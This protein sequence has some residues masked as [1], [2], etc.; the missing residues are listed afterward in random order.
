[1]V[2]LI[3]KSGVVPFSLQHA[4]HGPLIVSNSSPHIFLV[5]AYMRVM[6]GNENWNV[7]TT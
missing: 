2:L 3:I 5:V 4:K 6:N 1:M 7:E